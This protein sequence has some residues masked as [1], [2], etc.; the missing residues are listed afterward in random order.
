VLPLDGNLWFTERTGNKIGQVTPTG[1]FT[2]FPIPTAA[3]EPIGIVTGP[4]GNL[5]FTETSGNKIGRIAPLI[6]CSP[7]AG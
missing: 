3:T 6:A 7:D 5:W 4:D 1:V 2:E